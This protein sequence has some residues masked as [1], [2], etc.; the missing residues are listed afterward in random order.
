MV[1]GVP[2][3]TVVFVVELFEVPVEF[4]AVV[5]VLVVGFPKVFVEFVFVAFMVVGVPVETV[6]FVVELFE[7]PVEIVPAVV[8]FVG[9]TTESIA[10]SIKHVFE[11]IMMDIQRTNC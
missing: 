11:R 7:V 2:V 8:F 10:N 9:E 5:I 6:A 3:E 4:V 1:V